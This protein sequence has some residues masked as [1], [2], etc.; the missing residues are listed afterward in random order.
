MDTTWIQIRAMNEQPVDARARPVYHFEHDINYFVN[1]NICSNGCSAFE[2]QET[3]ARHVCL[4]GSQHAMPQHGHSHFT[5]RENRI[6]IGFTCSA[7]PI[8]STIWREVV[9]PS[10][11]FCCEYTPD[12]TISGAGSR[13]TQG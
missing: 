6:R 8:I 13:L 12:K 4:C 11:Y 7:R 9:P 2:N 3:N 5:G 10:T 1:E